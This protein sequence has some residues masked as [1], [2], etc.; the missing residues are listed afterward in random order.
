MKAI[1]SGSGEAATEQGSPVK[2]VFAYTGLANRTIATGVYGT[3]ATRCATHVEF[4]CSWW[5]MGNLK[6]RQYF[7]AAAR[8]AGCADMVFCSMDTS[9]LMPAITRDWIESWVPRKEHQNSA[10]V[11]LLRRGVDT[12]VEQN[13]VEEFFHATVQNFGIDL[14]IKEFASSGRHRSFPTVA[15]PNLPRWG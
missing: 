9:P 10:L 3:L 15:P 8:A 13:S 2:V 11:L 6:D 5:R 4:Q 14:F 7:H 12:E 1:L